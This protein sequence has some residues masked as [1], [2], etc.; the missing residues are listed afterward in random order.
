MSKTENL[1]FDDYF[2][3]HNT[4]LVPP[5]LHFKITTIQIHTFEHTPH[6]N[7]RH[8]KPSIAIS[9]VN[10][11]RER[12]RE[13][14]DY[15]NV[16]GGSSLRSLFSVL[17]FAVVVADIS[18]VTR[19]L[20]ARRLDVRETGARSRLSIS[21][22]PFFFRR[23]YSSLTPFCKNTPRTHHTCSRVSIS[24]SLRPS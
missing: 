1:K 3:M 11:K 6:P 20:R 24:L 14:K 22:P 10:R 12:E 19:M 9:R 2:K 23:R 4:T 17:V 21:L 15:G 13:R 8:T 16:T 7:S 5:S 18:I